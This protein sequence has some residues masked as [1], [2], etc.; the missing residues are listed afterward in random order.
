MKPNEWNEGINNV[1][2]DLVEEYVTKKKA[3]AQRKRR[4]KSYRFAAVAAVLVLAIGIPVLMSPAMSPAKPLVQGSGPAPIP[5]HVGIQS[6]GTLQF[7]N[8]VAGPKYPDMAQKPSQDDYSGDWKAYNAAYSAWCDGQSQQYNQPHGYA[9]SLTSFFAASMA[10][11]L[12]GDGNPTYAPLNVYMAMA[13]LAETTDGNSRQ[14]ILDLF[15]LETIEQLREQVSYVWNAH[16]NNDGET[17]LV[18]ANSLWLDDDYSFHQRTTDLL[19]DRY[20]A[21]SFHGDLGTDDMN[22]QLQT[23]LDANTGG[24]LKDQAQN[25]ELDPECIFMLASAVYFSAGWWNEFSTNETNDAVFHCADKDLMIP[26]MNQSFTPYTYYWGENYGAVS[27]SLSG[28]N[29]MWLILP[30]EGHTVEEILESDD[31]LRMTLDPGRWEKKKTYKINLSLPKFDVVSQQ[32]LIEGMKNLGVTDIFD[33]KISDFTPITDTPGLYVSQ[34]NHAARI[35]IDEEGC[36]AAAFTVIVTTPTSMPIGQEE[37]DF[38]LDRPFLFV[39]SSRSNLPI[40]AG[41]VNEP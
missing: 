37:I 34:I 2:P 22:Q 35:A 6:S 38:I 19:A 28:D 39:V 21:S 1:D 16:Y 30:D 41:V 27:L 24:L 32:D 4:V 8:L 9:D 7:A 12:T 5:D 17:T 10:E 23:W 25:V 20:Y 29:K 14:Q 31:Y 15:G 36:V 33:S 40:F 3:Y 18:M 26:F 11:F 13:M